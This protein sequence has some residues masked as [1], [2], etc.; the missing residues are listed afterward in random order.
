MKLGR[1]DVIDRSARQIAMTRPTSARHILRISGESCSGGG[2][3][4]RGG[5]SCRPQELRD[6][7]HRDAH[8]HP[9]LLSGN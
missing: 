8:T 4:I 1:A 2:L 9:F 7:G 6:P 3:G 5:V